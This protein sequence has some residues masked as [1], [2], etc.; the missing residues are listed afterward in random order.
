M[1]INH[2]QK[3]ARET[4]IYPKRFAFIYP[5]LGLTGEFGESIDKLLPAKVFSEGSADVDTDDIMSETGDIIWYI[6]NTAADVG[7][8][9]TDLASDLTN[10]LNVTSFK[11]LAFALRVT[12]DKRSSF[13]L[14]AINLGVIAEAAKKSLRDNR[15]KFQKE[16]LPEVRTAL[17][18]CLRGWLGICSKY[19]LDPDDVVMMNIAKLTDRKDRGKLKGDGDN[20]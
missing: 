4:A 12:D 5:A 18:R 2:Y 14:F 19:S 10:G 17:A 13:L 1:M 15:G 3:V 9:L 6:A 7:L 8:S 16:K 11:A 20:R